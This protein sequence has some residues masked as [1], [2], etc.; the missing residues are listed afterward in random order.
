MDNL[1]AVLDGDREAFLQIVHAFGQSIP[2]TEPLPEEIK[3]WI[4]LVVEK[5][6]S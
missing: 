4:H 6:A 1:D 2:D 3:H 5:L